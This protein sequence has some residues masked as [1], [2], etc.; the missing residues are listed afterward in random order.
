VTSCA[1]CT[2]QLLG[3]DGFYDDIFRALR[4]PYEPIR[5]A[6][7]ISAATTTRSAS[8]R[9]SKSSSTPTGSAVT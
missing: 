2:G 6:N 4:I 3:E 7:D 5:W 8:R 9:A 1:A